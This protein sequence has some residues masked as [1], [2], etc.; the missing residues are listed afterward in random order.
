MTGI[1]GRDSAAFVA[2]HSD[3]F[4][5]PIVSHYGNMSLEFVADGKGFPSIGWRGV[6]YA[7]DIGGYGRRLP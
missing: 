5:D 6:L 4:E 3:S 2:A 7:A 1:L